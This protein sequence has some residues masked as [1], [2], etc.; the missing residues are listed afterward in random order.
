MPLF[1]FERRRRCGSFR[2]LEIP[3]Y[4]GRRETHSQTATGTPYHGTVYA[5]NSRLR[6][7]SRDSA[8]H[9]ADLQWYPVVIPL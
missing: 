3:F 5:L 8:L 4:G 9:G 1:P 7:A 6:S 2:I